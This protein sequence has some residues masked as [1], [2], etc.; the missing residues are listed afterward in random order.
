M[1][2]FALLDALG[3]DK[4]YYYRK[5]VSKYRGMGMTDEELEEAASDILLDQYLKMDWKKNTQKQFCMFCRFAL[6]QLRRINR[7]RYGA[8]QKLTRIKVESLVDRRDPA[9][10]E[11]LVE[12]LIDE[13]FKESLQELFARVFANDPKH[14]E[15]ATRHFIEGKTLQTIADEL[16]YKSRQTVHLAVGRVRS[17]LKEWVCGHKKQLYLFFED[18]VAEAILDL[19]AA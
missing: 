14:W 11:A 7:Y 4:L 19:V 1:A 13:R 15:V 2:D 3:F 16:G 12:Q 9:E 18:S 6:K 8:T 10:D 17:R 5:E